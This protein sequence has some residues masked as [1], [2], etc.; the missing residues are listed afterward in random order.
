MPRGAKILTI[1]VQN[2]IPCIW[3]LVNPENEKEN[4]YFEI[5]RTGQYIPVDI[6]I[7]R[8]YINTFQLNGGRLEF[9]LFELIN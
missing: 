2:E 3:A 5:F 1:Q 4:R 7:E 6:G 8:K 9:H